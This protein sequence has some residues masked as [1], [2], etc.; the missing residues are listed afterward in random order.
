MDLSRSAD[1][2]YG[3]QPMRLRSKLSNPALGLGAVLT[4]AL[5]HV[6]VLA[7]VE[8]Y[9]V[10]SNILQIACAWLALGFCLNY[11]LR[12]R[13]GYL[14]Y[15]WLQLSAAFALWSTAQC[16]YFVI[17]ITKQTEPPFPSTAS[18]LYF[19]VAFPILMVTVVRRTA[20]KWEWVNWLDSA[21]AC[22]F[23]FV[24]DALVFS[25]PSSIPVT[26]AYDVQSLALFLT[27][28][29]RYST[30]MPGPERVFFRNLFA[31]LSVYGV[32][33]C[34]GIHLEVG[35]HIST[36]WLDLC[37]STPFLLFCA[38]SAWT[39]LKPAAL[40]RNQ[41]TALPKHLHGLSA[42]GLTVLAITAGGVLEAHH[43]V[44]GAVVLC[45]TFFLFALRTSTREF[46]LHK[47]HDRLE[48]SVLHDA[49]TG[50]ANRTQ[51]HRELK[52][53]LRPGAEHPEKTA[54]LFIDLDRFK[55]IND[56]LGHAFGDQLLVAVAGIL[57]SVVRPGDLLARLG[58]DE[59]VLL[60]ADVDQAQAERI[61]DALVTCLRQP[62]QLQ[63]RVLH[64]T[65]SVGV[66]LEELGADPDALLRD[67]DCAMYAAKRRGK[68]QVQVFEL[69]MGEK[70]ND[71]LWLETD[72]RE[73]ID[74]DAVSVYY[75][76]IYSLTKQAVVGFEALARWK[77]PTRGMISPAAFIPVAEETGLIL[78]LGRKVL[79]QAC[80]QV[81]QWNAVYQRN[82]TVSVNVSARQ[83]ADE[84]LLDVVRECLEQGALPPDRLKLEITESVLLSGVHLVDKVLKAARMLGVEISLDD[85]GTGYSSLSYLLRFPFDVIKIDR[86]FVQALDRDDQRA[87]LTATIVQLAN[88]LGKQV[89]AE[90]VETTEEKLCLQAMHCDLLQGYLFSRPMPVEKVEEML[91]QDGRVSAG[92]GD[93]LQPT[94]S[95]ARPALSPGDSA[96][97]NLPASWTMPTQ[98]A[99][100]SHS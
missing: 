10:L 21:Q 74:S 76:P 5:S 6:A 53:R 12:S 97:M 78:M 37:W 7:F 55:T 75:Q 79:E 81:A 29:L 70:A 80:R 11:A 25:H 84:G 26:V 82:Y 3:P 89:I 94:R 23:F 44:S 77:H 8:H 17:L 59:F 65:A 99:L 96:P 40:R 32:A 41:R 14:R 91:D 36:C 98:G 51:L 72:L 20:S 57:R 73:A 15:S 56:G 52:Q 48:Y 92:H 1:K 24:L 64:I 60:A 85:F 16:L 68:N 86:S 13:D 100:L 88:R 83:F 30:A 22:I 62:I 45:V 9:A 69:S 50:L 93:Q 34:L 49:L 31:F 67:A 18:V 66:V 87:H 27:G 38:L 58:G 54:L 19:L 63:G 71:E 2:G 61:G 28:A 35:Y 95:T 90:G 43:R 42:L 46:Q 39:E 47:A 4:V 33:V